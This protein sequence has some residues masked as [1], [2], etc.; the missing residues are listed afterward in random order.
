MDANARSGRIACGKCKEPRTG[1][2]EKLLLGPTPGEEGPPE[3][4]KYDRLPLEW[5]KQTVARFK[6]Q[7][8]QKDIPR[9][10]GAR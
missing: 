7:L 2:S 1:A 3:P 10:F 9:V 6:E 4:A 5:N 8:A